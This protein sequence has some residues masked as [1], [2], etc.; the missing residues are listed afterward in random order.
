MSQPHLQRALGF[1]GALV[2][3]VGLVVAATTLTSLG[4]AFGLG[5]P[6]FAVA[7]FAALVIT[8]LI[9][10]SYSELATRI[11]GAGMIG[12][13]T[14]PALGRG[15]AIFGV[16]AGYIVL[17]A[18]VEPAEL[19]VSGLAAEHLVPGLP[20]PRSRWGSPWRSPPSTWSASSHSVGPR[21][22]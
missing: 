17:V 11:P 1:W 9:A 2:T 7:G 3:G 8:T 19:V 21:S 13:Y 12:D 20:P 18:T 15:P 6:M 10:F 14:A 4:N 5:G 16:L 22:W